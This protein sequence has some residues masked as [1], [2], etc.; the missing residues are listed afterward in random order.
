MDVFQIAVALIRIYNMYIHLKKIVINMQKNL[1]TVTAR[2][3]PRI[4]AGSHFI[5]F[6]WLYASHWN[7][8]ECIPS[9]RFK[10]LIKKS[11]TISI[12][13]NVHLPVL[14]NPCAVAPRTH[15]TNVKLIT[16]SQL[17]SRNPFSKPVPANINKFRYGL[18]KNAIRWPVKQQRSYMSDLCLILNVSGWINSLNEQL[19]FDHI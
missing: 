16:S 8:F 14:P 1:K 4:S 19:F 10:C 5:T 13:T 6:T 11:L 9:V 17:L 3:L 7:R 12:T 2:S 18:K 15:H